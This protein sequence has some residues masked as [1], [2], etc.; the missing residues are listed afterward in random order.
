MIYGYV[1]ISTK[2]QSLQRQINNITKV[3]P[4]AVI[5]EETYSG[6]GDNES[7]EKWTNLLKNIKPEDTIVFDSVSRMSR[8]AEVGFNTY[9]ELYN[10]GINLIFLKENTINTDAFKSV[11][12]NSKFNINI[13]TSDQATDELVN[14][15]LDNVAK[16]ITKL[17]ENQ[18]KLAFEQSQK[19]VDDLRQRTKEGIAVKKADMNG[20]NWGKERG[21]KYPTVKSKKIK[22]IIVKVNKNFNGDKNNA[23]TMGFIERTYNKISKDTFYRYMKELKSE[24][25]K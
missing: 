3:Y 24:G 10:K 15:L 25:V 19:E 2:R 22:E 12:G 11:L 16:Y 4:H 1:R 18:I 14:G 6:T 23:D 9:M 5:I 8:D 21:K 17:A 13:S 7:R 20:R